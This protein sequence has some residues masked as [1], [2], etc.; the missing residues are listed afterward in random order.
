MIDLGARGGWSFF[1]PT[2]IRFGVGCR[3]ELVSL[4]AGK[5]VLI[6]TTVRGKSQ[7]EEDAQ[8]REAVG[9]C[10][11]HFINTVQP[12]PDLLELQRE[13]DQHRERHYDVVLAFGGGSA[14]DA[15]KAIGLGISPGVFSSDLETLIAS[16][17]RLQD[18]AAIPLI[19]VPTTAGTGSEVTPF[20][21][22][23]DRKRHKKL[24]LANRSVA[25]HTALVDPELTASMPHE[26]TVSTGLDALN[27]AFESVWNKNASP[28]SL[29]L[30]ARAIENGLAAFEAFAGG[31]SGLDVRTGMAQASVLAG[32]CISQTRTALCHAISYPLTAH[33]DVPHGIACA[34]T[35]HAVG[36]RY[37]HSGHGHLDI[38]ARLAGLS[39][40]EALLKKVG[41]LTDAFEVRSRVREKAGSLG[42]I[43]ALQ[44]EMYTPG[45]ADNFPV[46]ISHEVLE[47]ILASSYGVSV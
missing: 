43:Q 37:Q 33:F 5:R 40:A 46:P 45:R 34:F 8:L 31:R 26:V 15:A 3:Q 9:G 24:S 41:E 7:I 28:V 17:E 38:V 39:G 11:P 6:V 20:A 12:N 36:R 4:L 32:L 18:F 29:A 1:N 47:D 13:I 35:M 30:A 22:V 19:A 23:W 25:P 14:L 44:D 21:T 2:R 10:I 42:A 16:P 27:Q